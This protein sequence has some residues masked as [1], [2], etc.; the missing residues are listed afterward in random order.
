MEAFCQRDDLICHLK[1]KLW[2]K[3]YFVSPNNIFK[4]KKK[5]PLLSD[6]ACTELAQAISLS[7][8]GPTPG[9]VCYSWIRRLRENYLLKAQE[10][11]LQHAAVR[12][13]SGQT[14]LGIE[15][16]QALQC[17]RSHTGHEFVCV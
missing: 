5:L 1:W 14:R 6:L 8:C 2:D 17:G 11:S 7:S 4:K 10:I 12:E 13:S 15:I 16:V 9:C 3:E